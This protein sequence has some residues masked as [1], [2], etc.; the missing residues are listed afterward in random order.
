MVEG[1]EGKLGKVIP[2][3]PKEEIDKNCQKYVGE[4]HTFFFSGV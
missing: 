3:K 4:F 2:K 1:E